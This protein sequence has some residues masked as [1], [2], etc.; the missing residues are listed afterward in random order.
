MKR[1][2]TIVTLLTSLMLVVSCNNNN[3]SL[4]YITVASTHSCSYDKQ[5]VEI[6]YRLAGESATVTASSNANWITNINVADSKVKI[7]IEANEGAKRTATVTLTAPGYRATTVRV[8]QIAPPT[9]TSQTLMFYFFGTSL[10]RYFKG[11]IDDAKAAIRTGI[12]GTNNRVIYL[13]QDG[14]YSARIC[15]ICYDPTNKECVEREIETITVNVEQLTPEEIAHNI[16][17]M[18]AYAPADRYGLVLAGHGQGWIT[19]EVLNG[20]PLSVLSTTGGV[21]QQ[22]IGAEVTRALGENNVIMQTYELAEGIEGAS[23]DF[24]YIL[25]DACFMANIETI[26][27]MRNTA[28]YIIAS[29]CEI[30]GRGFPY[31]RTLPHL[32][33]DNGTVTDY[34]G[35]AESYYKFYDSEYMGNSRCGS[36]TV[37]DCRE[38]EALANATAE[39]VKS[40]KSEYD[41]ESLQTYEGQSEH[42]FYDF[43]QW[44]NVVATDEEALA[45]FNTQ[46]DACIVET[47]TLDTFY[48]AYGNYGTYPIDTDVYTGVTTS[49]PSTYAPGPW[50]QTS[51]YKAV[52]K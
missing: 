29:P 17:K 11:N 3:D 48:S 18:A 51:W 1:L 38:V 33:K 40:A 25:F 9:H 12:L 50:K 44:A 47:F 2:L 6:S 24:D 41:K 32:F 13:M 16:D 31:H 10:N 35:A 23:I 46:L 22:A 49:A 4:P 30:M 28:N 14:K 19:R 45:R 39:V 34:V 5:T 36:I 43:G 26:Y 52:W 15:E 27:D 20:S 7:D 42:H 21:W 8:T 37:F